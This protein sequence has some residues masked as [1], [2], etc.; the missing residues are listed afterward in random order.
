VSGARLCA[1]VSVI[2]SG[3]RIDASETKYTPPR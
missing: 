3:S 2:S 1:I